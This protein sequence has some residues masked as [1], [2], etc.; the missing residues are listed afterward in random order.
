MNLLLLHAELKMQVLR[1]EQLQV[2]HEERDLEQVYVPVL[3]QT[4]LNHHH[5]TLLLVKY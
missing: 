3:Q 4:L 5:C 2:L 1:E